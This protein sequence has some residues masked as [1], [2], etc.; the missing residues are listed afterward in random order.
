MTMKKILIT[1][2]KS[3]IGNAVAEYLEE[4]N[5]QRA[6]EVNTPRPNDVATSGANTLRANDVETSVGQDRSLGQSAVTYQVDKISLQDASWQQTQFSGYDTILHVAGKAHVDVSTVSE[7]TKQ[8]Y[9]RVNSELPAEVAAKAKAEGV[10]QFIHLSSVIIYGDSAG[11]G[12]TKVI[13]ADTPPNPTNFYGDSKLQ[14]E[15]NLKPLAD[16]NFKVAILRLPMVYGKDSK[17]NYPLLAK[18][19][20][21]TP[22]FPNIK[23][24]RSM[25]Y[26]ENLAEFIRQLVESGEGGLY[27]PQNAE[28]VTTARMVQLIG[29]AKGKKIRLWS[30][31]NP[32]VWL[33][34]KVPGKIGNLAN[35]AFGSLTVDMALSHFLTSENDTAREL[36][37]TSQNDTVCEPKS[38]AAKERDYRKYSLEESIRR[39][40]ED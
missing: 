33:A 24:Q 13:T 26:V 22:V 32:A 8:L 9:Y 38:A 35:K 15:E 3:Y 34:S 6:S 17:G 11:V 19:A 7:E 28:Y 30:I 31:L 14:G 27:F 36:Q 4:W 29:A 16:E 1:G 18:M 2:Q 23:N 10:K 12:K 5:R 40:H 20:Q 37:I 39:I 25:L 21:V